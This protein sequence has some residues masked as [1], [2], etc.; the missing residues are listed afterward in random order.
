MKR[1]LW[2]ASFVLMVTFTGCGGSSS[3]S[4]QNPPP[5]APTVTISVSP[6]TVTAGTSA[7]VTWSSTNATSCTASGAW[8]GSEAPSGS[9]SVTPTAAG[10]DTYKLECNGA[11]GS[12]AGSAD[13]TVNAALA[14][15]AVSNSSPTA[16]SPLTINTSGLDI[17]SPVT[18]QFSNSSG[19]SV[20]EQPIRVNSDASIVAPVPL[21]TT[22]NGQTGTEAVSLV[23]TQGSVSSAP[24][25]I[26]I[27]DLPSASSYG[28]QP[29]Q[30]SHGFLVYSAMRIARRLA[31]LQAFQYFPGNTVDT[32]QAQANLR[33]LLDNVIEMRNDIDR[34]ALNNSLVI[35]AG[36]LPDGT[37]LQF[38][39]TSLDMMDRMT[40]QYINTELVPLIPA[41][42]RYTHKNLRFV[43]KIRS[44]SSVSSIERLTEVSGLSKGATVSHWHPAKPAIDCGTGAICSAVNFLDVANNLTGLTQAISDKASAKDPT[45]FDNVLAYAGGATAIYALADSPGLSRIP[46]IG[47]ALGALVSGASLLNNFGQELGDLAFVMVA[48][49]NGT[50]PA[51]IA[52]A[53]N[54][55]HDKGIAAGFAAMQT[56]IS[57]AQY[58]AQAEE[59]A[60]DAVA[61]LTSGAGQLALQSSAFI[62]NLG[63][64]ATSACLTDVYNVSTKLADEVDTVFSSVT[65][66]FAELTGQEDV[67]YNTD[68]MLEPESGILVAPFDSTQQINGLADPSGSYDLFVPLQAPNTDYTNMTVQAYDPVSAQTLSY[69]SVDLSTLTTS[70]SETAPTM[71]ATCN[72][73]DANNPDADDPDCD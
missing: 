52:E 69:E 38:D 24:M 67:T 34:I 42:K 31:E 48:S 51:V 60:V 25:Q 30:I 46:W 54:D 50:D 23:L 6:T 2:F 71:Q 36:T 66:G 19:F 15:T 62:A 13:L 32:T 70:A 40:A 21:L 8:S 65:Q 18:V 29:G 17:T 41:A 4:T 61:V 68:P 5:V 28:M 43:Q 22:T 55:I 20:S 10:K 63:N 26:T 11:G 57:L 44:R 1:V 64:C 3:S 16:L 53:W 56:E 39:H 47:P 14:V 7:T 35:S 73:D 58:G 33:L 45:F 72:D 49:R 27:Q 9:Q 37:A 12:A 59:F